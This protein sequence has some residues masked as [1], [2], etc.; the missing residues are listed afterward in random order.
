M[1]RRPENMLE[2]FKYF[3]RRIP[4]RENDFEVVAR[5]PRSERLTH[6]FGVY[7]Q[8]P[9]AADDEITLQRPLSGIAHLAGH[10]R[11]VISDVARQKVE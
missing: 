8:A 5:G 9:R 10:G 7:L 2:L 6:A 4:L 3:G 11:S 1:R